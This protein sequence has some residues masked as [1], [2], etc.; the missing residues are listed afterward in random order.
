[1]LAG[2]SELG[3][4]LATNWMPPTNRGRAQRLQHSRRRGNR[5]VVGR[6]GC[7]T[8]IPTR[9]FCV[10]ANKTGT[11]SLTAFFENL[12][13]VI[14][15]QTAG[16]TLLRDYAVRNFRP[17]IELA[18]TA[19]FFQ[20]VPFSCPLTFQA[21]DAAFPGSKFILSVRNDADQWCDSLIRFHA[22]L[23]GKGR[24]PTAQDP[25]GVPVC[26]AGLAPSGDAAHV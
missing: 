9:F 2:A 22:K 24:T 1:M 3:I 20:D 15:S 4:K 12:G 14:G 5:L 16:E 26:L 13:F 11:T 8:S 10:G 17:I 19:A 23:I 6:T 21:L 18:R 25:A 7:P